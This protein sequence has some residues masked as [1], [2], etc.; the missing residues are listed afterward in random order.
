MSLNNLI[1]VKTRQALSKGLHVVALTVLVLNM[2]MVGVFAVPQAAAASTPGESAG[3]TVSSGVC[4]EGDVKLEADAVTY[5]DT[6][7]SATISYHQGDE[8]N[9]VT[10]EATTGYTITGVCLKYGTTLDNPDPADGQAGPYD[11]DISHVVLHTAEDGPVLPDPVRNEL[12]QACGMPIEVMMVIDR[13]G[14]M[15]DAGGGEPLA[16]VKAAANEFV[17]LMNFDPSDPIATDRAGV[18]SYDGY[19]TLRQTLTDNSTDVIDAINALQAAGS[20]NIGEGVLTGQ[21]DLMTNKRIDPLE[22][23]PIM[24]VLSDGVANR[25]SND[26]SCELWPSEHTNCTIDA[27]EQANAA[28]TDDTVIFTIGYFTQAVENAYPASIAL[29]RQTMNYMASQEDYY[30]ETDSTANL[31]EIYNQ[32]QFELCDP[33]LDFSK[34]VENLTRPGYTTEAMPAHAGD[35]IKYSLTAQTTDVWPAEDVVVEDDISDI[36]EY[37]TVTNAYDG[38]VTG[39]TIS[40]PAVDLEGNDSVTKYFEVTINTADTWPTDGDFVMTNVYGNSTE[41]YIEE[42]GTIHGY[43]FHDYDRDGEWDDSEPALNGITI[44]LYQGDAL[45][46]EMVTGDGVAVGYYQF[47]DLPAG[48][49]TVMEV[50]P[51]GYVNTTPI[52]VPVTVSA[53]STERV[54]FGND[55]AECKFELTKE[56]TEYVD[57]NGA[58]TYTLFYENGNCTGG[59]VKVK[60]YI[61]DY[62]TYVPDSANPSATFDGEKVLWNIGTV[63]PG[64]FGTLTFQV[65]ADDRDQ[66]G[67]W[68]IPN[69]AYFWANEMPNWDDNYS[70]TVYTTVHKNCEGDLTV[71]KNVIGGEMEGHNPDD[72]TMVANGP[73]YRE[74]AGSATGVTHTYDAGSYVINEKDGPANYTLSFSENCDEYGNVT[75]EHSDNKTCT[76][77]NE[78]DT[79]T[80]RINKFVEYA[81]GSTK[82]NPDNW[83]WQWSNQYADESGIA[84]GMQRTV[85]SNVEYTIT[86][87]TTHYPA[88]NYNTSWVCYPAGGVGIA[89]DAN[90][91]QP[92]FHT[93]TSF[94]VTLEKDQHIVCTFTNIR[95][96][97]DITFD[98]VVVGSDMADDNWTFA[99]DGQGDYKDGDTVTL[100]TNETFTVTESS[101]YDNLFTLTNA[102]GA[103]E[104]DNG[105][106]TLYTDGRSDTC[107]VE[108]T[109]N[110]GDL[111]LV[112]EITAS[113]LKPGGFITY[114]LTYANNGNIDLTGVQITDDYP[115][116]YVTVTNSGTGADN[117]DTI[118]WNIG[119]LPI[120]TTGTVTYTVSID[121][122]TPADTDIINIAV[123]T[124]DQTGPYQASATTEIPETPAGPVLTI[125]KTV[126]ADFV[127]PGDTATYTVVI[128]NIGDTTATNVELTD[129]LPVGFTFVEFSTGLYTWELGDLAPEASFTLTYD[130]LIGE[131]VTVGTYENFAVASADN[132]PNVHDQALLEVRVPTVLAEEA[133]PV[134]QIVKTADKEFINKGDSVTYT[135][136]V[137]N[138]GDED[139]EAVA[140]NI[141]V[142][143]IMP[144]GFTFEDGTVTKVWALGDLRVG[145]SREISYTGISDDTVLPGMYENLAV[146]WADN[147]DKV[148][149][150]VSVEVREP[151]VLGEELPTTGGSL[152]HY[153]YFIAA[154]LIIAFAAFVLKLT[155]SPRSRS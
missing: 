74:F 25:S 63:E 8:H 142:Q 54:D 127:N 129:L 151:Q 67:D 98:K 94:D 88:D 22:A 124:S 27:V 143:D 141:M 95:E 13:S 113:E 147:H 155:A 145:E 16:S 46:D 139:A 58:I 20:T 138:V 83:S 106:I 118:V 84:G 30:F 111:T 91:M 15:D 128:E 105:V 125:D 65:T 71:I 14:S 10:W 45:I 62:T 144:A 39:G 103:C 36:L 108:N 104:L 132:H 86:E 136:I 1:S 70:N 150:S 134:L 61:P 57:V 35:V 47:T 133:D 109:R 41:V 69:T 112:K 135:V 33:N 48:D 96:T 50:K 68:E 17:N 92:M 97:T 44:K 43:K 85:L 137:T 60:D 66:C 38:T 152:L 26:T 87:D 115:Q 131:D 32:I 55:A 100:P 154:G 93:G 19:A 117:G 153:I 114:Q 52:S 11:H 119:D 56:A 9:Y 3:L 28:K 79:A 6:E 82:K 12:P 5:E 7:G 140:L 24:I 51:N 81:D 49:Y 42:F 53:N 59:G 120:D 40:Y 148:D 102:S 101:E 80:V 130:V 2:S 34:S 73:E 4:P 146:A 99:V 107:V 116:Q 23:Q 37:A 29:A 149:D 90:K 72:W 110:T 126:G 121:E 76:L 18:T 31:Q 75:I 64:E 89:T 77:T 21:N 122:S 123:I 78:R